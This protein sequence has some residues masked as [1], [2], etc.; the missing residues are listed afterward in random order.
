MKL[1]NLD[2]NIKKL[3]FSL[4]YETP[5][6]ITDRC[7]LVYNVNGELIKI[8][9]TIKRESHLKSP[10]CG[11]Y[12]KQPFNRSKAASPIKWL[13]IT[14]NIDNSQELDGYTFYIDTPVCQFKVPELSRQEL[15]NI[16]EQI[17]CHFEKFIPN[18]LKKLIDTPAC[19]YGKVV[20][21]NRYGDWEVKE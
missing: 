9:W 21:K 14:W 2:D 18:Y 12:N 15:V 19:D 20:P 11:L 17:E 4:I 16:Q 3:F 8:W 5:A 1:E 6:I 13:D 7:S 10:S